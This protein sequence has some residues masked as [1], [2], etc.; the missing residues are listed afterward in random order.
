[1]TD[2]GSNNNNPHNNPKLSRDYIINRLMELPEMIA[3][4]DAA[5]I[6]IQ[7]KL[8]WEQNRSKR[9]QNEFAAL[10]AIAKLL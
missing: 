4:S 8:A 10:Q 1:M 3:D 7:D 6:D 5:I 9:L 2:S